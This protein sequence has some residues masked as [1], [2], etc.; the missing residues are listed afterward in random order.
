MISPEKGRTALN[1]AF[2]SQSAIIN[3]EFKSLQGGVKVP[4]GGKAHEP[5]DIFLR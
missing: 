3:Y 2:H 5:Y 1:L 4:T